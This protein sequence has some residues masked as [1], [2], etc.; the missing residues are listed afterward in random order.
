MNTENV[1]YYKLTHYI[2]VKLNKIDI[3]K[4][5]ISSIRGMNPRWSFSLE[6]PVSE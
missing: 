6:I 3:C 2:T 5:N 4:T 1:Q